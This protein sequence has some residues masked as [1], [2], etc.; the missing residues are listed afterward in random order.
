M[1][2][3]AGMKLVDPVVSQYLNTQWIMVVGEPEEIGGTTYYP[4]VFDD[5]SSVI[6]SEA[7]IKENFHGE[8]V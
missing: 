3:K 6:I 1:E 5:F 4:V 8:E 2:I 7:E